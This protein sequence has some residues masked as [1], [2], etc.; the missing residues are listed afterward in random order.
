MDDDECNG[1]FGKQRLP[2]TLGVPQ[3]PVP[4]TTATVERIFSLDVTILSQRRLNTSDNNF[5]M[6]LMRNSTVLA[7]HMR[8]FAEISQ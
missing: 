8:K 1:S 3:W 5:E 7:M 2:I 4:A 6:A